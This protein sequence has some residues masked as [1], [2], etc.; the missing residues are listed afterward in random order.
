MS[1]N[2]S[3]S[4]DKSAYN[5]GEAI[6][7]SISGDYTVTSTSQQQ[8]GTLT[9]NLLSDDGT[10]TQIALPPTTVNV[11]TTAHQNVR[12]TSI[13]DTSGRTWAIAA[14]GKS[15]TATA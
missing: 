9:L 8:S 13:S 5:Q 10:T 2:V 7:V 14:D 4:Y 15:A 3:G 11:T 12:V 6:T 1:W